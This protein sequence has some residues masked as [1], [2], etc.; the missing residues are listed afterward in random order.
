MTVKI[1]VFTSP[2]C[3]HCPNAIKAVKEVVNE[4]DYVDVVELNSMSPE[5]QRKANL[6]G[7]MSVPT[8]IITGPGSNQPLG[9]T[10]TPSKKGLKNMIEVAEGLKELEEPKNLSQLIK[11]KIGS[12][13]KKE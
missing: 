10:G 6:Y 11:N 5:G 2:T 8:T 7:I 4:L 9:L 13:F 3:P 1:E 12:L